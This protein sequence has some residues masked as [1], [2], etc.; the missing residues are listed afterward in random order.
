MK[1]N[2]DIVR[3]I[4]W[5]QWSNSGR[6]WPCA[7]CWRATRPTRRRWHRW[8]SAVASSRPIWNVCCSRLLKRFRPRMDGTSSPARYARLPWTVLCIA[9]SPPLWNRLIERLEWIVGS[10]WIVVNRLREQRFKFIYSP[11]RALMVPGFPLLKLLPVLLLLLLLLLLLEPNWPPAGR[12]WA[13]AQRSL[14]FGVLFFPPFPSS[15]FEALLGGSFFVFCFVFFSFCC[16]ESRSI[17][18]PPFNVVVWRVIRQTDTDVA[19]NGEEAN[20][21]PFCFYRQLLLSQWVDSSVAQGGRPAA[22]PPGRSSSAS[23]SRWLPNDG[24]PV[25]AVVSSVAHSFFTS[26]AALRRA[27]PDSVWVF[28]SAATVR[29]LCRSDEAPHA[30]RSPRQDQ[31]AG[32]ASVGVVRPPLAAVAA[33]PVP[34]GPHRIHQVGFGFS[35]LC[36]FFFFKVKQQPSRSQRDRIRLID[37]MGSRVTQVVEVVEA[38]S[39][40]SEK[41]PNFGYWKRVP[42]VGPPLFAIRKELPRMRS[43]ESEAKN[44]NEISRTKFRWQCEIVHLFE[45]KECV[46]KVKYFPIPSCWLHNT[47]KEEWMESNWIFIGEQ[48]HRRWRF[49]ILNLFAESQDLSWLPIISTKPIARNRFSDSCDFARQLHRCYRI[50]PRWHWI[51]A[52]NRKQSVEDGFYVVFFQVS[53]WILD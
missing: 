29:G 37:W 39:P 52:W 10:E 22:P 3:D 18:N 35:L 7:T 47:M 30:A 38:K 53:R 6:F 12:W 31:D 40:A 50:K 28:R 15:F 45:F 46:G 41:I 42:S 43:G 9:L 16:G 19:V 24:P 27:L 14:F 21:R 23:C 32:V 4:Y 49:L 25:E 34:A 13:V 36:L 51:M 1:G 8:R 26:S 48:W 2:D 5:L 44:S 11:P 33:L 17:G 20:R